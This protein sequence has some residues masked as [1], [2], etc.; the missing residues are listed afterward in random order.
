LWA[1]FCQPGGPWSDAVKLRE[2]GNRKRR[3]CSK[4][5]KEHDYVEHNPKMLCLHSVPT[6]FPVVPAPRSVPHMPDAEELP[7]SRS[8]PAMAASTASSSAS[9]IGGTDLEAV[10]SSASAIGGTGLEAVGS[11]ASA[12]G[13][14]GLEAGSSSVSAIAGTDL[15][16][17]SSS[18][19]QNSRKVGAFLN[20]FII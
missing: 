14:T 8:V 3:V 13:G 2:P 15:E 12:I 4:H 11:S 16:A 7:S 19:A 9:A 10:G 20:Y 6:L 18:A 1:E 17:G 5:F